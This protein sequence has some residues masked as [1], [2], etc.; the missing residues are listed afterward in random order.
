METSQ[1]KST[2]SSLKQTKVSFLK[3]KIGEQEGRTEPICWLIPVGGGGC[4]ERV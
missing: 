3:N 4:G 2:Y 1:G